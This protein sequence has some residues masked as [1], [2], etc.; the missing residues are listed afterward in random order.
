[1]ATARLEETRWDT[2]KRDVLD[3]LVEDWGAELPGLDT[4]AMEVVGRIT[5]L[6][7][8]LQIRVAT[9]LKPFDLSYSDF[10]VLATLRRSGAPFAL[11]PTELMDSVLLTS[12]A[13]TALL[14]RLEKRSLIVRESDASDG[15]V[16]RA[17][18]TAKGA[19]LVEEAAAARFCEAS[20]A[21][22]GI[23]QESRE[24]LATHLRKLNLSLAS[25]I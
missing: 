21:L 17:V 12:G 25:R 15:R 11:T 7:Q 6:A 14:R 19:V 4:S 10:D 3:R 8:K 18:L 20:Q 2:E 16:R 13:I 24:A 5:I 9:A 23:D 1:M 22:A